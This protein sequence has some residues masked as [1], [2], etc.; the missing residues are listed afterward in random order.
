MPCCVGVWNKKNLVAKISF[1][2]LKGRC[3]QMFNEKLLNVSSTCFIYFE[4][5]TLWWWFVLSSSIAMT[6]NSFS[7]HVNACLLLRNIKHIKLMFN[8]LSS[9]IY[10]QRSFSFENEIFYSGYFVLYSY[11]FLYILN[12]NWD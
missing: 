6:G 12:P 3:R 4:K 10:V 8:N 9:N 11:S 7:L 1:F 5:H 2:A